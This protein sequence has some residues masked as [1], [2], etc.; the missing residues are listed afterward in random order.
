MKVGLTIAGSDSSG[1]AGLQTDVKAMASL[2]VHPCTVV[3]C[4]TSQNTQDVASIYPLPVREI[5]RQLGSVL[6]D[7]HV[8]AAKTGMLHSSEIVA[9]V[10]DALQDSSFPLVVDPVMVATTE[11]SLATDDLADA[12]KSRL[13][14]VCE[15]VTPNVMEAEVLAGIRIESSDD[16]EAACE[17]LHEMGSR[18]VLIKGGHL[19]DGP[20]DVLLVD[21]EFERFSAQ[22]FKDDVHGSG[23]AFSAFITANLALGYDLSESVRRSK[24]MITAGFFNSYRPGKGVPVVQSHYSEDRYFVW[25][26]LD[27]ALEELKSLLKPELVPEVGVNFGHAVPFASDVQ[28]VVALKG[29]IIKV[30]RSIDTPAHIDF[31]TSGHISRIILTAMRFDHDSRSAMNLRFSDDLVSKFNDKGFEVA[32]FDRKQEPEGVSTMEWG[33]ESV[34]AAQGHVPDIIFDRGSV[35]K[36]PMIRVLGRSPSDVVTK[37]RRALAD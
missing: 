4:V 1:G 22:R 27:V 29:R 6:E 23:C 9:A 32:E 14:P 24:K 28:D 21:G 2:G 5:E 33:T 31:G 10:A 19:G 12:L 13:L 37:L 25:K 15:L 18:N 11:R 8:D 34:I 26:E 30:G 16:V 3:T 17:K 35:G 7:I 36:E 20:V